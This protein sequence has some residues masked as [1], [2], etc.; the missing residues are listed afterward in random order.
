MCPRQLVGEGSALA[1]KSGNLVREHSNLQFEIVLGRALCGLD[2]P[3][4]LAASGARWVD[5]RPAR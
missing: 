2:G 5:C 4:D 3:A 1:L